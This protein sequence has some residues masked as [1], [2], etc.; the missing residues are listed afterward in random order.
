[1][2]RRRI[3]YSQRY[4]ATIPENKLQY[5][6]KM[7]QKC[8]KRVSC[9][10]KKKVSQK[11]SENKNCSL[12]GQ[13]DCKKTKEKSKLRVKCFVNSFRKNPPVSARKVPKLPEVSLF[14]PRKK[15]KKRIA[16]LKLAP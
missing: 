12:A 13:I 15:S 4:L 16:I 10:T 9:G 14:E 1:M 3:N 6:L 8:A 7:C 2:R 11:D 5:V